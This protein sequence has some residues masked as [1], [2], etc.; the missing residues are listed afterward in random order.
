MKHPGRLVILAVAVTGFALPVS[1][2]AAEETQV[3]EEIVV[4]AQRRAES[5]QEVPIAITAFSDTDI[6]RAGL[7]DVQS[8]QHKVPGL[9]FEETFGRSRT[10]LRG[11]SSDVQNA[12]SETGV[13]LY[14]D[15]VPI[16]SLTGQLGAQSDLER[17]EVLRGPQ[18]TLYGRNAVGG[19]IN[20]WTK[21]PDGE[22]EGS[23]TVHAGGVENGAAFGVQAGYS[24]PLV[25]N[26]LSARISGSWEESDGNFDNV[27]DIPEDPLTGLDPDASEAKSVRV[28]LNYTP[29]DNLQII[30]RAS[31]HKH[32]RAGPG[33]HQ[34]EDVAPVFGFSVQSL[35][36]IVSSDSKEYANNWPP[37]TDVET[38]TISGTISWDVADLVFSGDV[39]IKSITAYRSYEWKHMVEF[40]GSSLDVGQQSYFDPV[41]GDFEPRREDFDTFSQEVVV[42][43]R[44]EGRF[45]WTAGAFYYSREGDELARAR[46]G[47]DILGVPGF[48]LVGQFDFFDLETESLGLFLQGTWSFTDWARLTAGVRYTDETKEGTTSI[49]FLPTGTCQ[50]EPEIDADEWTPHFGLEFDVAEATMLYLTATK[51]FR[52]GGFNNVDCGG[53]FAVFDP[54][55]VWSYEA[56]I[57]S[58]VLNDRLQLNLAAFYLDYKDYQVYELVTLGFS[59]FTSFPGS[60]Q[61][62][63]VELDFQPV[64]HLTISLGASFM[65]SEFDSATTLNNILG[66]GLE[67]IDG[68]PFPRTPEA[69]VNFSADYVLPAEL[70]E[71]TLH[72]DISH[73]SDQSP[74]YLNV[75]W[76]MPSYWVANAW[77][78]LAKLGGTD[79]GL[80]LQLY[81][82]NLTDE[83][84][85]TGMFPVGAFIGVI[86]HYGD[87]LTFGARATYSF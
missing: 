58:R 54:E 41:T 51:G 15:G 75:P 7:I 63:E 6:A 42:T 67:D 84:Y 18:G 30:T 21:V 20:Y 50:L 16:S 80:E 73:K 61:G 35:G 65:D 86:G 59:R 85:L 66:T 8:L 23:I 69:S 56:G 17:I 4:T 74:I 47:G 28:V 37:G 79:K 68:N 40:E 45:E 27:L 39:N 43:S 44:N 25:E 77:I 72:F 14:V 81:V 82:D 70:A 60:V 34:V 5:I 49:N 29:T 83:E 36:A 71:I 19:A 1:P 32:E 2:I 53:D 11:V 9:T 22:S 10:T 26:V 57:K 78:N 46:L 55:T 87:P 76:E 62:L 3:L 12:S 33:M 64:E 13:T 52:S 31:H 24:F 48:E 38:T